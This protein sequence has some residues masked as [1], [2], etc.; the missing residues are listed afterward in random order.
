MTLS[1][2]LARDS[3]FFLARLNFD[4][5][6]LRRR[7]FSFKAFFYLTIWFNLLRSIFIN[8]I[9]EFEI[10]ITVEALF[11]KN[12]INVNYIFLSSAEV[13]VDKKSKFLSYIPSDFNLLFSRKNSIA[14]FFLL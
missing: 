12:V 6:V 3:R 14:F 10:D 2:S 11:D 9:V 8:K 1:E 4:V 5:N 13:S 7:L